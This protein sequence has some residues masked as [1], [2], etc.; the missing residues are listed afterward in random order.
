[1]ALIKAVMRLE[2]VRRRLQRYGPAE[3][4]DE[5]GVVF[6]YHIESSKLVLSMLGNVLKH[7]ILLPTTW[8]K[9]ETIFSSINNQ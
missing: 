4:K 2:T 5:K 6:T 8:L 1:M 9:K 7:N 3:L